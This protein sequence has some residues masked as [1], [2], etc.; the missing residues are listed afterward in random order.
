MTQIIDARTR[1][2]YDELTTRQ[3]K[4]RSTPYPQMLAKFYVRHGNSIGWRP[5]VST[6]HGGLYGEWYRCLAYLLY[7]YGNLTNNDRRRSGLKPVR[8]YRI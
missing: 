8:K 2:Y 5:K 7:G 6:G 1:A 3:A 4:L